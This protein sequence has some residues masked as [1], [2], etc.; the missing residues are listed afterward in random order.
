MKYYISSTLFKRT[1]LPELTTKNAAIVEAMLLFNP[2]YKKQMTGA[3]GSSGDLIK[4]T[5][6]SSITLTELVDILK[7]IDYEYSTKTS[8]CLKSPKAIVFIANYIFSKITPIVFYNRLFHGDKQLVVEI[9]NC[10]KTKYGKCVLSFAS[11]ICRCFCFWT[12]IGKKQA[13]NYIIYD[14]VVKKSLSNYF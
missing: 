6:A 7:K 12:F 10:T 9:A 14:S 2:K 13:D 3:I 1:L 5:S 11:K 8:M 4:K